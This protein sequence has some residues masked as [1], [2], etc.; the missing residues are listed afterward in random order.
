MRDTELSPHLERRELFG[1]GGRRESIPG[2]ASP[3]R[4]LFHAVTGRRPD[5]GCGG[6]PPAESERR[7]RL[8]GAVG[9]EIARGLVEVHDRVQRP[10]LVGCDG[11]RV[12]ARDLRDR[13]RD[14]SPYLAARRHV[15]VRRGRRDRREHA[16]REDDR[17][18]EA[19]QRTMAGHHGRRPASRSPGIPPIRRIMTATSA[20]ADDQHP[21]AGA[22]HD[23]EGGAFGRDHGDHEQRERDGDRRAGEDA[24]ARQA[25]LD[26]DRRH[27]QEEDRVQ[28]VLAHRRDRS[29]DDVA[30]REIDEA[31][32]AQPSRGA[33]LADVAQD[34]RGAGREGERLRRRVDPLT[35]QRRA[36]RVAE[37]PEQTEDQ[38]AEER[39]LRVVAVDAGRLQILRERVV[40][41]RAGPG[42][43]Q[44]RRPRGEQHG[45]IRQETA[46]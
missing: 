6:L 19:D 25:R 13:L 27:R 21:D 38:G 9:V 37:P 32:H 30:G 39:M 45:E 14:Q 40:A 18:D 4:A 10:A 46:T 12:V 33:E 3:C 41:H 34:E 8:V 44:P 42:E 7:E 28:R 1:G 16:L 11:V 17:G 35:D 31:D 23:D 15:R 29:D 5:S 43:H 2:G 24:A 22:D 26:E 36:E 20:A